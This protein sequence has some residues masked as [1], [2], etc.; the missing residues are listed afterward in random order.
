MFPL[1]AGWLLAYPA[2][3]APPASAPAASAPAPSR[4]KVLGFGG[5]FF[6]AKDPAALRRWYQESLGVDPTPTSYDQQPWVQQAGPTAFEPMPADS[7]FFGDP[8]Q[9]FML[10]FRVR[11]LDAMVAQLRA[12]S[13]EVKVDPETY[14]NGRFAQLADPEGHPIQLWEDSTS[15]R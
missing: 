8:S 7:A 4:E 15:A 10:N 2:P 11:D 1:L 12:A 13:I 6:R 14:P 3:A 9:Q 5:F